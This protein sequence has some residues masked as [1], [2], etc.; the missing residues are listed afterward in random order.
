MNL[1]SILLIGVLSE[2][3]IISKFFGT[4][5]IE[6]FLDD[7]NKL[8][9]SMIIT[10]IVTLISAITNNLIYNNLLMPNDI[11]YLKTL[12][13][14]AVIL[15]FTTII[16]LIF[17]LITKEKIT[18]YFSLIL[19]NN[20]IFGISLLASKT[21]YGIIELVIYTIGLLIGYL[22]LSYILKSI[23]DKLEKSPINR[24]FRGLPIYFITL[25]IISMLFTR[26][27]FG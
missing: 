16:L 25:F 27:I 22:L 5:F 15:I 10:V 3:I 4:Y 17:K 24:Y 1:I 12:I 20:V 18:D 11:T 2:N 23:N 19:L 14:I 7:K 21:E 13:F 9:K 26:Y 6:K 8:M